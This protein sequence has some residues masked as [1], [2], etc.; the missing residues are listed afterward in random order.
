ML[1]DVQEFQTKMLALGMEKI[2]I[3]MPTMITFED[4]E[5]EEGLKIEPAR[6]ASLFALL[7]PQPEEEVVEA[8]EVEEVN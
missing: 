1:D 8:V 6:L 2:S 3:V 7:E 4:L 5:K